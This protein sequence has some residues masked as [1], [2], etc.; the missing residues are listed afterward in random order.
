MLST[1]HTTLDIDGSRLHVPQGFN[2]S[3][4]G[5]GRC[6]KGV[7]VPMT[8]EDYERVSAID[9][10]KDEATAGFDWERQFRQLV[11]KQ[12]DST[13]YT[14]AIRPTDTGHCPFLINNLCHIHAKYGEHVKPLICGLF[15]Y[16][17]NR[18]PS[19]VYLTVSFRS[20]AVLANTGTPLAEQPDTLAEKLRVY[21][22]LYNARSTI[23]DQCKLTVD[24]PII[25]DDY[26][27]LEERLIGAIVKPDAKI[28]QIFEDC[29]AILFAELGRPLPASNNGDFFAKA[30]AMPIKGADK[31]FLSQLYELYYPS[32]P[33]MVN[34]DV[35]FNGI[36]FA[37]GLAFKGPKFRYINKSYSF[38]TLM[39]VPWPEDREINDL[40]V[41]F[42]YSRVFGKWYFGGGF[43]QLSVISGFHHLLLSF[44]LIRLHAT[45]SALYRG[46][47]KASMLDVM[48][49]VRQIE[50]KI[51]VAELDGYSAAL[52]EL[53]LFSPGRM[54]RLLQK[55]F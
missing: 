50:E 32:D 14:H 12:H 47:P 39:A 19:G 31:K 3:C 38:E 37:L 17:F 51:S 43:A 44:I 2:Y 28:K 46:E 26:L 40:L 4:S 1:T 27:K 15:P 20:N 6:C 35:I 49:S 10:S 52:W 22:T 16:S 55:A 34:R 23:W 29:I 41:R 7:A 45:A 13:T 48:T 9:W 53:M 8:Q 21:E 54:A 11:K 25:W 24:K 30:G 36:S 42:L 5:C 33:R 18:T